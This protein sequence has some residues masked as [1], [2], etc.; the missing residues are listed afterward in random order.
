MLRIQA[1]RVAMVLVALGALAALGSVFAGCATT[2]KE[3]RARLQRGETSVIFV[4]ERQQ[5]VRVTISD[6]RG[7][8]TVVIQ[9][10]LMPAGNYA[11]PW[12][13]KWADGSKAEPGMYLA[14]VACQDYTRTQRLN[15]DPEKW[16]TPVDTTTP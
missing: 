11:I 3:D 16:G 2:P 5:D 15:H 4:L 9:D 10:G 1:R 8:H 14:E 12:D 7:D 13:G 6:P